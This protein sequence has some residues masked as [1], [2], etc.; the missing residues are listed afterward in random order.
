VLGVFAMLGAA[1]AIAPAAAPAHP[2][3]TA[4]VRTLHGHGAVSSASMNVLT[5]NDFRHIDNRIS[6]FNGPTGRL[7]LTAPE[8][9][10]DPD[11]SGSACTLD[12][13]KPGE[14]TA[15]E[16]SCAPGY[17]G[18]IVGDLGRG[19]DTF[20][21]DPSL[22]VMIGSITDQRP[23]SGGPGRDRLVGGALG[24]LFDGSGGPD[25]MVGGGGQDQLIG[26]PGGDNLSGGAASDWLLGRGGPD[27]LS[28]GGGRDLCRG[29]SGFDV[30]KSC[31]TA[32]GI[33]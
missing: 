6:V 31:E 2:G 14:S 21:A 19:A 27:K 30:G 18:A 11:G 32:R 26:G 15:P 33:P 24:D 9:L 8:G 5:V 7:T 4:E 25:S 23:L 13:A 17:I 1:S 10:G 28:G 20:D 29:A 12:N 16:V 22:L 3:V